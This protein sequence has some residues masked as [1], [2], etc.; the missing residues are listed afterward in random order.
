MTEAPCP[1]NFAAETLLQELVAIPSI[2]GAETAAVRH[3]V[4][5]MAGHGYDEAFVDEVG[6]AVGVRGQG[7]HDLLLLGHIDTFPGEL[8]TYCEGRLLYGRG[9]VDAKGPLCAFAVA[10]ARVELPPGLRL[11]VV[12]AS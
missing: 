7:A 9:A 3:L 11:V 2:T 1:D 6:N 4:D 12:G 8:P 5:W 10:G